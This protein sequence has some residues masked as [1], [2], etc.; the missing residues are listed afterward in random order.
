MCRNYSER[1]L[2][3]LLHQA[4]TWTLDGFPGLEVSYARGQGT[5]IW[6]PATSA[7]LM[8]M[9]SRDNTTNIFVFG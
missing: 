1:E 3:V 2:E 8:L 4:H 5:G 7:F 9:T 6:S